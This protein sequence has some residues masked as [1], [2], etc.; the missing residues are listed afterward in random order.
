MQDYGLEKKQSHLLIISLLLSVLLVGLQFVVVVF[1]G[2]YS[3]IFFSLTCAL[4]PLCS[5]AIGQE[6]IF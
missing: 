6:F 4:V 1:S 3:L 5:G 2:N